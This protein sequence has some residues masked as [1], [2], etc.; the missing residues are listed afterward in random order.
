MRWFP[1]TLG[2]VIGTPHQ[3]FAASGPILQVLPQVHERESRVLEGAV[4]CA[5]GS[6]EIEFSATMSLVE[7]LGAR[8][9][10]G[11]RPGA[12]ERRPP[13]GSGDTRRVWWRRSAWQRRR[14]RKD[15]GRFSEVF[16]PGARSSPSGS[17]ARHD[18]I[19]NVTWT[20]RPP[21]R[22]R[23][24]VCARAT[25]SEKYMIAVVRERQRHP[26][27]LGGGLQVVTARRSPVGRR[28][29]ASQR[30]RDS[31]RRRDAPFR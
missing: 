2:M 14:P 15:P 7:R 24:G 28:R 23:H 29:L 8:I 27:E 9:A 10:A 21:S 31:P 26:D 12:V 17:C 6:L 22:K 11:P 30:N 25:S 19:S 3:L 18:F 16:P 1:S 5:N 13:P 4:I 20:G